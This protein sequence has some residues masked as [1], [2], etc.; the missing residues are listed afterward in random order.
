MAKPKPT[1]GDPRGHSLRIYDEVYDS[2]AFKSLSPYDVLAYLA[3]L[4]ELKKTNNGDLSLTLTRSEKCGINHHNTLARSLRALC[5]VGLIALTRKGGCA[6]GGRKLA[7][8]YRVTDV[9]AY[10]IP[11]KGLEY[12]KAT[13][14]WKQVTSVADGVKRIEAYEEKALEE[15]R[16]K[17]NA[18][19]AVTATV[20]RGALVS[21]KTGTR[22]DTSVSQPGHAVSLVENVAN[23]ISMRF[24]EGFV[25]GA[26]KPSPRTPRMPPLHYCHTYGDSVDGDGVSD[27]TQQ[28]LATDTRIGQILRRVSHRSNW[29]HQIAAARLLANQ[30]N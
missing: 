27:C 10:E 7:S 9:E 8:L 23:P 14:D 2:P 4:R 25:V 30:L 22:R 6:K 28:T 15:N 18:G 17:N 21:Q 13:N 12:H 19:H 16:K 11:A 29:R 3:L 5:A 26:E 1:F 20:A 24:S